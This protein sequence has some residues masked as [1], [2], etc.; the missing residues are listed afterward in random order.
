M[1][2][3]L[4]LFGSML[5]L[6][7][8]IR[9]SADYT[10][11][12]LDA[13]PLGGLA[14]AALLT[15]VEFLVPVASRDPEFRKAFR[16]DLEAPES[17]RGLLVPHLMWGLL[18]IAQAV[19]IFTTASGLAGWDPARSPGDNLGAILRVDGPADLVRLA[20]VIGASVFYA[21]GPEIGLITLFEAGLAQ[22]GLRQVGLMARFVAGLRDGIAQI[23]V[24]ARMVGMGQK[25]P[26]RPR[27]GPVTVG[28]VAIGLPIMAGIQVFNLYTT[29]EAAL[30]I[31]V[32]FAGDAGFWGLAALVAGFQGILW[33]RERELGPGTWMVV[34]LA[35]D[36]A[37]ALWF[38]I[39]SHPHDPASW[40]MG[41]AM[42]AFVVIPEAVASGL[43]RAATSWSRGQVAA[44][45]AAIGDYIGV[46]VAALRERDGREPA[47][48]E[49]AR[50]G[51]EEDLFA[52]P[53]RGR[54]PFA[55]REE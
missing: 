10:G 54:S 31:L 43:L 27:P 50:R 47:A 42:A 49:P 32:P 7:V 19:D 25:R 18:R 1:Y 24:R 20:I 37:T 35:V 30:D 39:R 2:A 15:I 6:Y 34:S 28:V 13:G 33:S 8:N 29:R 51:G 36:Y 26:S 16:G 17:L 3:L 14:T 46:L 9:A 23:P 48:R 11:A 44:A 40:A 12:I 45:M 21:L 53:V 52:T 38:F 5:A 41:V 4:L 55:P 22:D